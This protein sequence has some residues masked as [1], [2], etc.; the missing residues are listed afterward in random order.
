MQNLESK[1]LMTGIIFSFVLSWS[2]TG[3]LRR[4]ALLANITDKPDG[5]RKSQKEPVP[6]LGGLA[7]AL[8]V[9]V[10]IVLGSYF[11][12]L[13]SETRADIFY[14]LVPATILS[15]V[16]LW[17]D[18]R[19]LSPQFRLMIQVLLGL[20]AS[21]TITF[22]STTGSATGNETLDLLLTIF[23]IVGITNALNFFDNLDGGAAVAG[24]MSALGLFLYS[25]LTNQPYLASFGVILMGVMLG[26]FIWNR[27]PARIYMGDS[28]ALFLGMLLATIAV[29]IDPQAD[30]KWAAFSVPIFLLALPILDTSTVVISRILNK[31]SP[32]QGGKDHL[33][34]RLATMGLRHRYILYLFA[35]ISVLFQAPI[36]LYLQLGK[37]AEYFVLSLFLVLMI[38]TWTFFSRIQIKYE[39]H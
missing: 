2:L 35:S 23:W 5:G 30:S 38:F 18:I 22:G 29:R 34:H 14:L 20:A 13:T 8:S 21:L 12:S 11:V 37:S 25:T 27:K 4:I 39:N 17:D 31:R 15:F 6:Y 9:L 26:F 16:G 33:S 24:F 36:F 3:I 28:G 19:E 10:T 1:Y 32:L 7:I